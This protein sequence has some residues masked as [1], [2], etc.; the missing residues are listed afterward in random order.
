MELTFSVES[1]W[2]GDFS[3][4]TVCSLVCKLSKNNSQKWFAR[5]KKLVRRFF[6]IRII[7]L[8][9]YQSV[10]ALKINS[11]YL[12]IFWWKLCT[13]K[14]PNQLQENSVEKCC[15]SRN[16]IEVKYRSRRIQVE[17]SLHLLPG[18]R[19]SR[20]ELGVWVTRGGGWRG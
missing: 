19:R 6:S 7:F 3:V 15:R 20:Y 9:I 17:P 18:G 12:Q 16:A 8:L 5:I 4:R 10:C 14:H 13:W 11:V 1:K 2:N